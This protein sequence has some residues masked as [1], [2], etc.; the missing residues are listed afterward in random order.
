MRFEEISI[1]GFS[2]FDILWFSLY[3]EE[4]PKSTP[5][6]F[7]AINKQPSFYSVLHFWILHA[8]IQEAHVYETH[9]YLHYLYCKSLRAAA[10]P[11]V[12]VSLVQN[13]SLQL[14]KNG[15]SL[16]TIINSQ[17]RKLSKIIIQ[18]LIDINWS[19][20]WSTKESSSS[21]GVISKEGW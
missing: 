12:L 1:S 9:K 15:A 20:S 11:L 6:V 21:L 16:Q 19:G 2:N 14:V 10:C 3:L 7:W 17:L 18:M 13:K 8:V 5:T 4:S